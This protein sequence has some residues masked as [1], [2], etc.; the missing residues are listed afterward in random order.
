M[1]KP[2]KE[3]A[4][5]LFLRLY[6]RRLRRRGGKRHAGSARLTVPAPDRVPGLSPVPP[7]KKKKSLGSRRDFFIFAPAPPTTKAAAPQDAMTSEM[8]SIAGMVHLPCR[9]AR[10]NEL[11]FRQP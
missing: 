6:R 8:P 4:P 11:P 2:K 10:Q 3:P 7:Q 5:A 1:T 9:G